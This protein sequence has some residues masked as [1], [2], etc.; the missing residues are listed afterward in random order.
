MTISKKTFK[1]IFEKIKLF[2]DIKPDVL[3][4]VL[5]NC[6]IK[7][8]SKNEYIFKQHDASDELYILLKGRAIAIVEGKD[9]DTQNL[10]NIKEWDTIGEL[11][12][13]TKTP[14]KWGVKATIDAEL[15]VIT[16]AEFSKLKDLNATH[17]PLNKK[18]FKY[19][20]ENINL[21]KNIKPGPLYQI[22]DDCEIKK[23]SKE[24]FLFK[25]N[26]PPNELYILLKGHMVAI[27]QKEDGNLQNVGAIK[28]GE[29]IGEMGFLTQTP[30][31]LSIKAITDAEVLII[32]DAEFSK[33]QNL[34]PHFAFLLL[35]NVIDRAQDIINIVEKDPTTH[36]KITFV[37]SEKNNS[38]YSEFLKKISNLQDKKNVIIDQKTLEDIGQKDGTEGILHLIDNLEKTVDNIM[39]LVDEDYIKENNIILH[40][41]STLVILSAGTDN[42]NLSTYLQSI[43]KDDELINLHNHK[44]EKI[45]VLLWEENETIY[46]TSNWLERYHF[47]LYFHI[48]NTEADLQR[49][50]RYWIGKAVGVVLSGGFSLCWAH[51]GFLRYL[52]EQNIPIDFIAGTSSGSGVGALRLICKNLSI[53]EEYMH[54]M[55]SAVKETAS[56][57]SATFPFVAFFDGIKATNSIKKVFDN[58]NIEDL[59]IPYFAIGYNLNTE[60]EVFFNKGSLWKAIRSSSS[61]PMLLPGV[62]RDGDIIIDGGLINN[63]PTDHM[64]TIFGKKAI[65]IASDL[66]INTQD[67]TEYHFPPAISTLDYIRNKLNSDKKK[68]V[69]PPFFRNF[70]K[71]MMAGSK[72]RYLENIAIANYFINPDLKEFAI[73]EFRKDKIDQ[74]IKLGY[75]EAKKKLVNIKKDL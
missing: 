42:R 36:T 5:N 53:T 7:K 66:G 57:T 41:A 24:E 8:V 74:L 52:E 48:R 56:I 9:T 58:H 18:T 30:R 50:K 73:L 11:G 3:Y 17:K 37:L 26:D 44:I 49:L 71:A 1:N 46:G 59:D 23:I 65:I 45:L 6:E 32:K 60:E 35:P 21:F 15:L 72:T 40:T 62:V 54:E 14:R 4:E 2:K 64:R 22:L 10:G 28:E 13:F 27:L 70:I 12:F 61:P 68:Y 29:T 75:E 34:N 38:I 43:I 33:L 20:F 47:D 25:Q 31:K 19:I 39:F 67:F 69:I 51:L 16:D 55:S 63:L